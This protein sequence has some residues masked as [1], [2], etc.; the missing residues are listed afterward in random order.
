MKSLL[1]AAMGGRKADVAGG[2]SFSGQPLYKAALNSST[3]VQQEWGLHVERC[4][5]FL[6]GWCLF[7]LS[8]H[9]VDGP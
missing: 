4:L 2:L 6:L 3:G 7:K 1:A 8:N 9:N 5:A